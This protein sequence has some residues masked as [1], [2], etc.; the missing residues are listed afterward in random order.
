MK[1]TIVLGSLIV[2]GL[3]PVAASAADKVGPY[4]S[5]S[6]L[7][8][9]TQD[10]DTS[11]SGVPVDIN[12]DTGFGIAAA[13]G[14]DFAGSNLRLEGEL[15]YRYNEA[16]VSSPALPSF[17]P[18]GDVDSIAYMANAYY[19]FDINS[20][21]IPYVGAG[22]GVVDIDSEDTVFAYQGMVGA[23]YGINSYSELF[24]GYR[25]FDSEGLKLDG[26]GE[27][28]YTSHGIEFGYRIRL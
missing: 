26:G 16:T 17:A 23:S 25:Y 27:M 10:D 21:L 15:T 1:K 11:V 24:G 20:P 4:V 6:G 12:F 28:D 5:F 9:F 7:A 8:A 18:S 14:Y 22:L 19:D 13:L 3:M 2:A